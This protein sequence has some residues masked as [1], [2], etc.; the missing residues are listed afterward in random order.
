[1]RGRDRP[2]ARCQPCQLAT[3]QASTPRDDIDHVMVDRI[4]GGRDR[5]A[6]IAERLEAAARLLGLYRLPRP[7]VAERLGVTVR[8]VDRYIAELRAT[9]RLAA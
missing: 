2:G 3:I 5:G 6:N 9:G 4:M 1:M 7:L 8:T